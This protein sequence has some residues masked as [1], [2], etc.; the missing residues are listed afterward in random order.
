[1]K[2]EFIRPTAGMKRKAL[3]FRDCFYA[4]GERT[5][6]GSGG[7]DFFEDYESWLDSIQK[8]ECGEDPGIVPSASIRF[9]CLK[10]ET[11]CEIVGILDIRPAL[12]QSKAAFGHLGYATLPAH[13]RKGIATQMVAWGV[14]QLRQKG[15]GD[16]LASVYAD[17]AASIS[18]LEKCGFLKKG[19]FKDESG[20]EIIQ[21][22][23][24]K[25]EE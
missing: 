25:T 20:K 24:V 6:N 15:V 13:R 16:V 22:V 10:D 9:A 19:M 14:E 21:Y 4:A 1:M 11:S 17:N 8:V 18:V 5:I 7:L 23:N 2:L 3:D 12:P